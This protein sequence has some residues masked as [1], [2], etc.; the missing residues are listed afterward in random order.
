MLERAQEQLLEANE[1]IQSMALEIE[2]WKAVAASFQQARAMM[3]DQYTSV[4]E[5]RKAR[6]YVQ[7]LLDQC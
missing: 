4:T 3:A 7:D 1:T 5:R 2:N 6:R